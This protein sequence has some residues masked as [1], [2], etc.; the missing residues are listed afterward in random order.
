MTRPTYRVLWTRSGFR[1]ADRIVD[2]I[3]RESPGNAGRVHERL[4]RRVGSLRSMPNRGHPTPELVAAGYQNYREVMVKPYRIVYRIEPKT[5][6]IIAVIDGRREAED[7][8]LARLVD[9]E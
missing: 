3:A 2:Y 1:D 4:L 9:T 5:V 8:L 6:W 7:L